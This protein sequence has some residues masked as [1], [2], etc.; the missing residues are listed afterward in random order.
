MDE[1]DPAR[2]SMSELD[3]VPRQLRARFVVTGLLGQ[4]GMGVVYRAIQVD[5]DRPVALKVLRNPGS[6]PRARF[7][8]EGSLSCRQF[9][10]EPLSFQ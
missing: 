10:N 4:G 5:L 3:A 6:M 1:R 2:G 9:V 8:R 7:E